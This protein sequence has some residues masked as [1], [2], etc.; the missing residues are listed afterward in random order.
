MATPRMPVLAIPH[1]GGP[2]FQLADGAMGPPGLWTRM[3][4]YLEGIQASLP[5][6]PSALLMCAPVRS[7]R[8]PALLF[9]RAARCGARWALPRSAE[10]T[11]EPAC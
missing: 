8:P 4:R 2:C 11:V 7:A 1:G 10:A 9:V 5:A 6:K 3:Q